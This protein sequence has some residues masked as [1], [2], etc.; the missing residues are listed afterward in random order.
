[1]KKVVVGIV[2]LAALGLAGLI[3]WRIYQ[4]FTVKGPQ[5][6]GRGGAVPIEVT[7]L[8][9]GEIVDV[10]ELTGTLVAKAQ[11]TIAPKVPGRLEKLY[12]DIGD[13]VR[14]GEPIA[15]LE[16]AEFKQQLAQ[17]AAELEVAK[18]NVI[19]AQSSMEVG[20]REME[21]AEELR[22]EKVASEAQLDEAQ[23]RFKASEAKYQVAL[24]QVRQREAALEAA[25]VR[26]SYTVMTADWQDGE[27]PRVV[28]ERFVDQGNMLRAND[29]IVSIV[30]LDTLTAVVHVIERDY[31]NIRP[32]QE[33]SIL[34]EAWA[35]LTFQGRVARVAPVLRENVRQ[36]RVEISIPNADGKLKPGMFVRSQIELA[37]H[38]DALLAPFS[39]LVRRNGKPGLFIVESAPA[40]EGDAANKP[41]NGPP[42]LVARFVQVRTGIA[43]GDVVEII[44]PQISGRVITLGHHLLEDGS[45]VFIP[46]AAGQNAPSESKAGRPGK[47]RSGRPQ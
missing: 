1:M 39:A 12:V 42:A 17:A 14:K 22:R 20:K 31:S 38:A 15:E 16:G 27:Q 33:A 25:R 46:Q 5:R 41:A 29:P 37:R 44:E 19:D 26:L 28:A 11:I 21:R 36:A 13:T 24:A 45:A 2:I 3:G 35:G 47:E 32:D 9:R 34:A 23:S 8:R 18:A 40:P 30:A 10:G 4:H 6:A 7:D 43:R